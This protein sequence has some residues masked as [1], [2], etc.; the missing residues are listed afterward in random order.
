MAATD[1]TITVLIPT[2]NRSEF[3]A[4]CLESILA[5]TLPAS[6]IIIVNEGAA[7][8][9]RRALEPYMDKIDYMEDDKL[10]GKSKAINLGLQKVT[11]Q[12]LWI[13]DDDDVALPDAL[14]RFV[15]PLERQPEHNFSFSTYFFTANQKENNKIGNVLWETQIPDLENRGLLIPLL[16]HNFLGGAALFTRSS[17]YKQVGNFLPDL[18]RAE[19]Y[20]MA[21]RIIR[22]H[23]GI[24]VAGG[25]TFHYRQHSGMRGAIHES[26]KASE[27]KKYSLKYDQVIFQRLYH[28]LPLAEYLPPG[29]ELAA[30]WRQALLQRMAIMAAKLLHENVVRDLHELSLL[31]DN[32][33]FSDQERMLIGNMMKVPFYGMGSLM[34]SFE[35]FDT[36]RKLSG[37]NP[38]IKKP[39]L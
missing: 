15:E 12:Y 14:E 33:T 21:I 25:A 22:Q 34:N 38:L 36:L 5:Q 18:L 28:E 30:N 20:E 17:V 27:I 1:Q 23:T 3:L 19:D 11:G 6:Q 32:S 13:F 37:Q 8:E 29:M 31:N 16:E 26:F 4:E 35:F 39:A 24:K 9:T 7:Q 2:Y 10:F